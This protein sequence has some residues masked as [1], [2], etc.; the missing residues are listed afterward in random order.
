MTASS[1]ADFQPLSQ[2]EEK[3]V[4]LLR[5][6][7]FDRLG[8]GLRP[9][10]ATPERVL[11][12]KFLRFLILGG[13]EGARPHE[14]GLRVS[15]A[16]VTGVLDLEGCRIA[17]DIG[18]KDCRFDATPV[19]RSAIIDSIFLDGSAFP[20]LEG[21]GLEA[22]GN[23]SLRG[24][25]VSGE[26]RL[27]G[28]RLGGNLECDG[29]TI[30]WPD[31]MA[32]GAGGLEARGGVLL[33]GARLRGGISL[34]GARLGSDFDGVGLTIER[35]GAVALDLDGIEARGDLALRGATVM[36]EIRAE[37]ARFG[38][39]VDCS[40]ATLA[41]PDGDALKLNRATI[42]GAFFLRRGVSVQGAINLTA[43]TIGAIDDDRESWPQKGDLLMNRCRYGAFIGGPVD[44][45]SRLDWLGLQ[46][47]ERWGEDFWP[48]PYEQLSA[49]F[50]EMGHDDDAR[51]VLITKERLQ[52]RARRART[53]SSVWRWLLAAKDGMLAITVRYGRQPLMA[54][55]WL[56]MF[57]SLG[58]IVFSVAER[59]SALKPN[60][61]VVLRSTEWTMCS[62]ARSDQ[63]FM[64]GTESFVSGRAAKDQ[65]QLSCFH[66]QPEAVSYPEFNAWMY[67]LDTLLPVLEIGQMQYWRP[68]PAKPF[69]PIAL[70]Y[71]YF[72]TIV[73]WALSLLAVAGFSG[74]VKSK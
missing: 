3:V 58:V 49:V 57:W 4:A 64:P 6:G 60:S 66:E 39:D 17:H 54:F 62:V 40:S 45:A 31:G 51:A 72:Q 32:I 29:A 69:G 25:T 16:F 43:A 55:L 36:G 73:G 5:T 71:F 50:R 24:A 33:R 74:L 22:R 18:L 21:E 59:Q 13:E 61:P 30:A 38:G 56:A 44:A 65:T 35:P 28:A 9:E 52:R 46:V 1:L 15:G 7:D 27:R 23:L 20:G 37:G 10:E 42:E 34:T 53:K 26:I 11:R 2:A 8:D 41:Q 19:L 14:K 68:D 12:A 67:S 47:P 63:R 48:Q 70:N